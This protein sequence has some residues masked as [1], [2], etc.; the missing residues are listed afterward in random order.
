MTAARWGRTRSGGGA[1][2]G[3]GIPV[4]GSPEITSTLA[5]VAASTRRRMASEP[6]VIVRML[7]S[8]M[9]RANRPRLSAG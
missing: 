7:R 5:P 9:S 1:G 2:G 8:A 3:G 6:P 4:D